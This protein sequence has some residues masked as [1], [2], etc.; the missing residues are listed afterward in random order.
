MLNPNEQAATTWGSNQIQVTSV[1]PI[2]AVAWKNGYFAFDNDNITDVMSTI[3]RWYD[4]EVD[5]EG[6]TTGKVFGGTISRFESFEKLLQTI[7]LT[8]TI[9]FKIKGRRVTVMT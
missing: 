2:N 3:A 4:I 9:Q 5:Y 6:D 1:D 8:G 7:G